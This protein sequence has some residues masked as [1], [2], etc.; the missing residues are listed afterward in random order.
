[1]QTL[2]E[3]AD[4]ARATTFSVL[5]FVS[6]LSFIDILRYYEKFR[7]LIDLII[8]CAEVVITF[9]VVLVI[10]LLSFTAAE[11]YKEIMNPSSD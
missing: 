10:M 4:S 11:Y 3:V 8:Q 5:M 9:S 6:I 1:V 2:L 7:Y